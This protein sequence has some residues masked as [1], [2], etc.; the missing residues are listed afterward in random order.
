[1]AHRRYSSCSYCRSSVT[2]RLV[3]V[4]VWF[5]DKLVM[6]EDVP[7]GVCDNCG[8]EYFT[9]DL[10]QRMTTLMQGKPKRTI[11]LPV[12]KFSDPLTVAK[13][14]AKEKR[15]LQRPPDEDEEVQIATDD[16]IE[17]LLQSDANEWDD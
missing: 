6:F 4:E 7:A 9:P 1:M 11:E 5:G 12:Y 2:E 10:Q 13:A 17:N 3:S 15:E 16:D 14:N 8:E